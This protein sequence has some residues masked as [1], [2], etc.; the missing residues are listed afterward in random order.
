MNEMID[1]EKLYRDEH[2]RWLHE[3]ALGARSVT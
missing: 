2:R 1:L 3:E